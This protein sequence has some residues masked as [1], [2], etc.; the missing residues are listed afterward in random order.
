MAGR[1]NRVIIVTG[2]SR[3]LGR[4]I[5]LKFG[6]AGT[7]IVVNYL[8]RRQDAIA[9]VDSITEQGG[10]AFALQAD[11]RQGAMVDAM[12]D[13]VLERWGTIDVLV[14]NAGITRDGFAVRMS[15]QDW[16][17]VLDTNLTGPFHCI[18]AVSRAMMRQRSGHII[19]LASLTGMQGRAGQANYSAAKAGLV[20]LT[21]SAA[22][23]LG[24]F[25]IRANTVLPGLLET[26]MGTSLPE[27]VRRRII[28]E[29]ALG[30]SSTREEVAEFIYRLSLM[31]HV[32]G[33]VFN[34]DSRIP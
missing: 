5:A 8:E 20:G 15:E 26:E 28:E 32:S 7:R 22:K 34:L 16:D 3:G 4:T 13:A 27:P 1:N 9:V 12:T 25:N 19:S 24:R 2:A 17:D 6:H 31:Q 21:Q 23:E 10:E 29:N 11:V 30:R 14:N 18:R 33:Q